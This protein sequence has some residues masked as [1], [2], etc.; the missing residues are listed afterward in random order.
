MR[1]FGSTREV[2]LVASLFAT[3]ISAGC[4]KVY[5]PAKKPQMS[6]VAFLVVTNPV[7]ELCTDDTGSK[8]DYF[9]VHL[10]RFENLRIWL[11]GKTTTADSLRKWTLQTYR[12]LPEKVLRVQFSDKDEPMAT[13]VLLPIVAALPDIQV[14][15][16]SFSFTCPKL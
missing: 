2:I 7:R 6:Q 5:D 15:R 3:L 1:F 12:H 9:N 16:V 14:R 4:R 8:T 10:V 13:Q 11:D